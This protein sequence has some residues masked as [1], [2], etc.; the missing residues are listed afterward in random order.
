MIHY[1][2][3]NWN[4]WRAM[5]LYW[6]H[7]SRPR[8]WPLLIRNLLSNL[9]LPHIAPKTFWN[10][11]VNTSPRLSSMSA[12]PDSSHWQAQAVPANLVPGE[13]KGEAQTSSFVFPNNIENSDS[14]DNS[15]DIDSIASALAAAL[16]SVKSD[17]VNSKLHCN[18]CNPDGHTEDKCR[19]NQKSRTTRTISIHI[20]S[21]NCWYETTTMEFCS[22]ENQGSCKW[23]KVEIMGVTVQR[24]SISAPAEHLSY[25]DSGATAHCFHSKSAF[26]PGSIKACPSVTVFLASKSFLETT[27]WGKVILPFQ[28]ANVRLSR[29]LFI[30]SLGYDLVFTI[31]LVVN[32]IE[33]HSGRS[34]A[35]LVLEKNGLFDRNGYRD[36]APKMYMFSQNT[37]HHHS[38]LAVLLTNFETAL[39]WHR[40][41]AQNNPRDLLN[42]HKYINVVPKLDKLNNIYRAC[43]LGKAHKLPFPSHFEN[44]EK[45]GSFVHSDIMGKLEPCFADKFRL[46]STSLDGKSRYL[47]VRMMCHRSEVHSVVDGVLKRF[48]EFGGA[49]I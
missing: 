43:R 28:N 16:K 19:Q 7:T 31:N 45:I 12:T 30:P 49:K 2:L 24:I 37:F 41:L 40:R 14:E 35:K 39:L 36:P 26:V 17:N 5:L 15:P 22:G 33:S 48:R 23:G 38:R 27:Q 13:K 20:I 42:L 4:I 32:G 8:Y 46:V 1:V 10:I 11:H 44:A 47:F 21:R 25:F 9:Q 6:K 3:L 29:V 18:F 34:N